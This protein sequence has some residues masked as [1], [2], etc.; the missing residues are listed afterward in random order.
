MFHKPEH[1]FICNKYWVCM[2][3]FFNRTDSFHHDSV[4]CS[5]FN[6]VFI[7]SW[8]I[9]FSFIE[10]LGRIFTIDF[11]LLIFLHSASE[12][13]IRI[14]CISLMGKLNPS[15]P[16]VASCELSKVRKSVDESVDDFIFLRTWKTWNLLPSCVTPTVQF[17]NHFI[18]DLTRLANLLTA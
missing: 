6:Q 1:L 4:C 16:A 7:Q 9:C 2:D 13:L 17:S 3:N 8:N 15:L 12:S 11:L 18:P 14:I 10:P 5:N